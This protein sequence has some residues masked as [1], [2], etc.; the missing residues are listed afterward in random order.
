MKLENKSIRDVDKYFVCLALEDFGGS[1]FRAMGRAMRHADVSNYNKII[2]TWEKE[3]QD[4]YDL[5]VIHRN[6]IV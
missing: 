1:F 5:F 6:K 2:N 4:C 3:I